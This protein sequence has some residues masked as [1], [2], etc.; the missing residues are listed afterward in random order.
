MAGA[1][2]MPVVGP[3]SANGVEEGMRQIAKELNFPLFYISAAWTLC[4]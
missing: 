4:P 3:A 1:M 2:V